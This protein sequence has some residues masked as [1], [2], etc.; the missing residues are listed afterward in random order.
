MRSRTAIPVEDPA[1]LML[2]APVFTVIGFRWR[3]GGIEIDRANRRRSFIGSTR[4]RGGW[5]HSIRELEH[6]LGR[7]KL[8]LRCGDGR[9]VRSVCVAGAVLTVTSSR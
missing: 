1:S 5:L 2:G 7:S 6:E 3:W 8:R 4:G 9:G